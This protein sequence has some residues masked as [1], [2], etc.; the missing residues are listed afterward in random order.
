MNPCFRRVE[1]WTTGR[2]SFRFWRAKLS[3]GHVAVRVILDEKPYNP[4]RVRC[5]VCA[6]RSARA[7]GVTA[8]ALRPRVVA[9]PPTDPRRARCG[10]GVKW[11]AKKKGR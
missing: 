6:D 11:K 8:P 1:G 7:L 3:C 9:Y 2:A 10:R 5:L 4:D